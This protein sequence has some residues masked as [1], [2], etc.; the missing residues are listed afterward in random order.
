MQRTALLI[1]N[2]AEVASLV[3]ARLRRDGFAAVWASTGEDGVAEF[4]RRDVD[5]VVLDVELPGMDGFEVCRR[6]RRHSSVPVVMLTARDS[7]SDRVAGLE[8]GADDYLVKPF[9]PRELMARIKAV[10]RRV[11]D[12]FDELA[13]EELHLAD[14]RLCP[15]AREVSVDGRRVELT[16]R[17]FDLLEFMMRNRGVALSRETL[18]ERVWGMDFAGGTRTV[19]VHIAQLRRKLHRRL[20]IRTVYG[21]GY[22]AAQE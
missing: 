22:I 1:E 13:N 12:E 5:V 11:E 4:E 7:V 8:V 10:I 9:A 15:A 20:L 19:G 16:P 17:E 14:V 3:Q 6:L 18:L 21:F 2:D